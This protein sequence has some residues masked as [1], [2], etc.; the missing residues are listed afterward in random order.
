M[1]VTSAKIRAREKETGKT[2]YTAVDSK[3]NIHY[4]FDNLTLD[5]IIAKAENSYIDASSAKSYDE[6]LKQADYNNS[7]NAEQA[8]KQMDFQERLSNTSHQREVEDLKKAGLNPVLSA[9]NGASTAS[10]SS[11]SADTSA[12]TAKV[13]L[14]QA[15][16]QQQN[17][18]YQAQLNAATA[19][20]TN[21][22]NIAS[23]QKMARWTNALNKELGYAG[24]NNQKDIANISAAASMYGADT[25]ASASRYAVDN[26]NNP[27]MYL[28]KSVLG[29]T[30]SGS[31][32]LSKLGSSLNKGVSSFSSKLSD[33]AKASLKSGKYGS[34][35]K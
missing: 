25:S 2:A 8:Q 11:A 18:R 9:N 7:F 3:G 16:M 20:E 35:S 31:S 24:L 29:D 5:S 14:A 34:S 13:A 22:Q 23:A 19:L 30:S 12:T 4:A 27:W 17:A 15:K 26:P 6:A 28:I 1:A 21:R 33:N 10:G 32:L